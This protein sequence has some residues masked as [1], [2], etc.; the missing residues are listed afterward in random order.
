M[1]SSFVKC[2]VCRLEH[3]ADALKCSKCHSLIRSKTSLSKLTAVFTRTFVFWFFL[4]LALAI[5]D[6][7][8]GISFISEGIYP[9]IDRGIASFVVEF[10]TTLKVS[11]AISVAVTVL[12]F[13]KNRGR[14][15]Y[16]Y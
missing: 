11:L 15:D 9:P 13:L 16:Y 4:T 1:E 8:F 2:P 6:H 7:I 3:E 14:R 10:F 12:Y 5:Y